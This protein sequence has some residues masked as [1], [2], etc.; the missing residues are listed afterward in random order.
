MTQVDVSFQ[1]VVALIPFLAR[2]DDILILGE[3]LIDRDDEILQDGPVLIICV[4]L[5][6]LLKCFDDLVLLH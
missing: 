5:H 4:I 1:E 6:F 3:H 2:F